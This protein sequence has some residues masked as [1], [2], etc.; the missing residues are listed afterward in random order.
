MLMISTY[1]SCL[2]GGCMYSLDS[3][4]GVIRMWCFLC[5][6]MVSM[7]MQMPRNMWECLRYIFAIPWACTTSCIAHV[8]DSIVRRE[9]EQSSPSVVW[10]GNVWSC[11]STPTYIFMLWCLNKAVHTVVISMWL[12]WSLI[13]A[14]A[15]WL[16][17]SQSDF[18]FCNRKEHN[19]S[20]FSYK[21]GI[22]LCKD[23]VKSISTISEKSAQFWM[24]NTFC[25]LAVSL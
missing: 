21:Q 19:N 24:W 5:A 3:L 25:T 18:P 13:V 20:Q 15:T 23:L 11:T 7:M 6:G 12:K 2:F 22:E 16:K 9:A 10:V 17:Y 8:K 4:V 1:G 14:L